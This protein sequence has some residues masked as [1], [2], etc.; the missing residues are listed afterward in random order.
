M[1]CVHA[2][3][4]Y[5]DDSWSHDH[6]VI[7]RC[8]VS[9]CVGFA[10]SKEI[11]LHNTSEIPMR[12]TLRVPGDRRASRPGSNSSQETPPTL[13]GV[14]EFVIRPRKGMVPPNCSQVVQLD[15]TP[16]QVRDYDEAL[17]VD[18]KGVG[19]NIFS[20]PIRAK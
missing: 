18:I 2:L 13:G 4:C 20:L 16:N 19:A 12:Y 9:V 10:S 7:T 1:V 6:H 15:L 3:Q 8:S 17:V 11:M 5:H 14:Q